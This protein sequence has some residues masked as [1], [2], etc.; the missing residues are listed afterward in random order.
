M[1]E[2]DWVR[3]SGLVCARLCHDLVG[4]VGGVVN[5]VEFLAEDGM[6]DDAL[7]LPA[8]S[9]ARA[10][11]RLSFYRL[12][13]GAGGNPDER[14]AAGDLSA[15]L[16]GYFTDERAGLDVIAWP[17]DGNVLRAHGGIVLCLAAISA[18]ALLR[19][20]TVTIAWRTTVEGGSVSVVAEGGAMRL[21]ETLVPSIEGRIDPAALDARTVLPFMVSEMAA[22][23]GGRLAVATDWSGADLRR[24]TITGDLPVFT[25]RAG[26]SSLERTGETGP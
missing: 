16:A 25:T 15:A 12:A 8:D 3:L 5:G 17:S 23:V 26:V 11:R 2:G 14:V 1:G 6:G 21:P 9:A 24:L 18:Q 22:A 10:A 13:L 20:G 4:P 19:G 7:Q